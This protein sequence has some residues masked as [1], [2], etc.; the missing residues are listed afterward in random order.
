MPDVPGLEPLVP[1]APVLVAGGGVTGKAVLSALIRFGAVPT[2]CDDDPATLRRYAESGVATMTTSTSAERLAQYALVVTSP[3]FSPDTPL[4]AAAATEGVPIWGDVELA[5]RLD[6]AGYYGPPRRWL[7]VTGTNGKTTTASM[8]QA[9]LTAAGRRSV[10]CGNIGDP[11]LDVLEQPADLLA[12]ELSSFQ[13]HWAPSVRPEAGVVLNIAEDHLDWHSTMADYTAAKARVLGGRVAV[14][15][16]DDARAAA[17][18]GTAGAPVRVGFRLGEPAVGELGVRDGRLVD[19]AFADDLAL[20]PV[21]SI[22]VPGPV[23]VLDALAAAALARSV[24]VPAEAIAEAVASFRVGRHR[25]EVVAVADGITYVDDS[26]ATNP[27][28]AEASVLAYPRVV[29]VAGGLL[30]GASVDAEVARMASRLVGAVLIGRDRREVAEALSR[31][32]PDV[33]VVQVVTGE[34][35]DMNATAVVVGAN[36][37]EVKYSGDDL[38]TS[39]MTAAVAAARDLARPGDTVLLAPAGA[40]FDQFT[41]YAD[42]GDA[43]AAAVRAATR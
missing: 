37:T 4:L 42:R 2:L 22:P 20:L 26:K 32:A 40:S 24:D 6:T 34:D 36:V 27:H 11:V 41:G 23:G 21:D 13:L 5:W 10:L 16:L 29:W 38:G 9:M 31:H 30:K 25:A 19:R 12:V 15:G 28:A 7:V 39:V 14:V 33:P 35:A 17:L 3:G 43:F 1:G 8:L 18:L